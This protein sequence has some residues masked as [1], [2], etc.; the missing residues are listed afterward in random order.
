MVEETIVHG[1]IVDIYNILG[2]RIS[3]KNIE[4]LPEGTYIIRRKEGTQKIIVR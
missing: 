2:Q 4:T 1:K 3:T